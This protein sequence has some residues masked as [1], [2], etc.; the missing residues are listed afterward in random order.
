MSGINTSGLHSQVIERDGRTL[1]TGTE[2]SFQVYA[3][4]DAKMNE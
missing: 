4:I 3:S 1:I 2:N